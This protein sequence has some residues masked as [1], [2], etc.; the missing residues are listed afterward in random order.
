MGSEMETT[1]TVIIN[2][3][4]AP[5]KDTEDARYSRGLRW[6]RENSP[7]FQRFE[8]EQRQLIRDKLLAASCLIEAR[9]RR[10]DFGFVSIPAEDL[11]EL[12]RIN[13]E[14]IEINARSLWPGKGSR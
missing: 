3:S 2:P 13:K 14:I 12:L 10:D 8:E 6:L 1:T 7:D 4:A 11:R 5:I 9:L